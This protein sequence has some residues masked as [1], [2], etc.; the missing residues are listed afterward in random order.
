MAIVGLILGSMIGLITALI[1]VIFGSTSIL[2]GLVMYLAISIATP[3]LLSLPRLPL[4]VW[5]ARA[6]N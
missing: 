3:V 6:M 4:I 1:A 5:R 2:G